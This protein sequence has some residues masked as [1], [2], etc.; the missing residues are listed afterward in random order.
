MSAKNDPFDEYPKP[1]ENALI[2]SF[3]FVF[4]FPLYTYS[5]VVVKL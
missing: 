5:G 2:L 4:S 3:N 1:T